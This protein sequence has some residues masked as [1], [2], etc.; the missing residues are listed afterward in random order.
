MTFLEFGQAP[1]QEPR[2][3]ALQLLAAIFDD[4]QRHLHEDNKEYFV[5]YANKVAKDFPNDLESFLIDLDT[6]RPY[7]KPAAKR[8]QCTY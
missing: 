2:Q 6:I 3:A 8:N 1:I 5:W 7:Y 4:A